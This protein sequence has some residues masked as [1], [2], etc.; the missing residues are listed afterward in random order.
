MTQINLHQRQLMH[1]QNEIISGEYIRYYILKI[2]NS[3]LGEQ[4]IYK[5]LTIFPK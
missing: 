2:Y 4:V 5:L 3:K 1:M